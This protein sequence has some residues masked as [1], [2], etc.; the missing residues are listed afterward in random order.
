[1]Y[2]LTVTGYLTSDAVYNKLQKEKSPINFSIAI[3]FSNDKVE[4]KNFVYWIKSEDEPK[5]LESLKKGDGV[6][7]LS[8]YFESKEYEDKEQVKRNSITE[9]VD[10]L[11]LHKKISK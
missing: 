9:Y 7:I 6:T 1:M 11:V 4:Y 2:N 8:K 5:I 10:T 3:N